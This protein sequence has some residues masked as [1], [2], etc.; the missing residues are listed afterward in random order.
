MTEKHRKRWLKCAASRIGTNLRDLRGEHGIPLQ[1]LSALTGISRF[2]LT[3]YEQGET[4]PRIDDLLL[5][6]KVTG[7]RLSAV[8][9]MRK[10]EETNGDQT[11]G[12]CPDPADGAGDH[13]RESTVSGE[14]A[15]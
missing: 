1:E 10:K 7:F 11:T 9:D 13:G 3:R 14:D 4:A 6:C 15:L 12:L 2:S 8:L 5:I